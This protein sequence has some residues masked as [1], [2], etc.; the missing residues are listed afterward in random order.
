MKN[1]NTLWVVV[2]WDNESAGLTSKK[3]VKTEEEAKNEVKM[4]YETTLDEYNNDEEGVGYYAPGTLDDDCLF[5]C[6]NNYGRYESC[7]AFEVE[8]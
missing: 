2:T 4:W 7:E 1:K 3:A 6:I 8:I 5:A